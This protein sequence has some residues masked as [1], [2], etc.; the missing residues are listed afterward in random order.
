M[1]QRFQMT[2]DTLAHSQGVVVFAQTPSG[3]CAS[4]SIDVNPCR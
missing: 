1:I 4:R 2:D 3:L